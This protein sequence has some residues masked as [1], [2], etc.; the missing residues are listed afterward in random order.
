MARFAAGKFIVEN[1]VDGIAYNQYHHPLPLCMFQQFWLETNPFPIKSKNTYQVGNHPTNNIFVSVETQT[2]WHQLFASHLFLEP[3]GTPLERWTLRCIPDAK[4]S[5]GP[6]VFIGICFSEKKV[7]ITGTGYAGEIKKAM[8]T[9]M[10]VLLPQ[11]D[12][13]TLHSSAV[14]T[15]S[16]TSMLLLGL[17]GTGKTTLSACQSL[18]IIGDDE[19]AWSHDGIFNLEGG[20]Y[21]KTINITPESEP[22]IYHALRQPAILENTILNSQNLPDFTDDRLT[23]NTRAAYPLDHIPNAYH[24]VAPHPADIVFLCYDLYGVIPAVSRLDALEALAYYETGYTA[25]VGATEAGS[26]NISP[27]SSPFFGLPF[28]PLNKATYSDLFAKKIQ[29]HQSRVWLINTGWSD[30]GINAGRRH[31]LSQTRRIIQGIAEQKLHNL[32]YKRHPELQLQYLC[33]QPSFPLNPELSPA[34]TRTASF[35][36]G[37]MILNKLLRSCKQTVDID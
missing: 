20:C 31:A 4:L 32:A 19:H 13:L 16:N 24:Q 35:K 14:L 11:S 3:S 18:R 15:P 1:E 37:C 12:I 5:Q 2:H 26:K 34:W 6:E 33:S 28:F 29:Q 30:G 36:Q 23:E 7:L 10:N 9:I 17:S 22:N 8:F 21:A 27:V 25:K